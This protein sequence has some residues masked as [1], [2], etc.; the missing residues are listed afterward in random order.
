MD[1]ITAPTVTTR[2]ASGG[3]S[4]PEGTIYVSKPFRSKSSKKLR[5]MITFAPRQSH[6]DINNEQSGS[7]E[8]RVCTLVQ[9]VSKIHYFLGLFHPVLD[10]HVHLHRQH[11]YK[12]VQIILIW[13]IPS[14]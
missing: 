1:K 13:I 7:N 3:F 10:I 4:T 14:T 9:H 12:K 11:L 8:F 5:A 6:F 2:T